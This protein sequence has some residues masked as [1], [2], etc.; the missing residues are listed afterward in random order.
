MPPMLKDAPSSIVANQLARN[1]FLAGWW[2]Y[3]NLE[4]HA[5]AQW[6]QLRDVRR[7]CARPRQHADQVVLPDQRVVLALYRIV[8]VLSVASRAQPHTRQSHT[9]PV[10]F[11]AAQD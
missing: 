3:A 9:L 5:V 7:R 4:Q 6:L 2:I 10:S 1:E 8:A 11:A